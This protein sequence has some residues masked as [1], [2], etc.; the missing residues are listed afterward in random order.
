MVLEVS[1]ISLL[2]TLVIIVIAYYAF[3]LVFRHLIPF[4][5]KLF[6]RNYTSGRGNAQ[7]QKRE[8][9][10]SIDTAPKSS[11]ENDNLGEYVDFK[12]IKEKPKE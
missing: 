12:E 7:K 6:I 11:V 2:R 10:I 3:K 8:G 4:L 5:F 9:E 1:F